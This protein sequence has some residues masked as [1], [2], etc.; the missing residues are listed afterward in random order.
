MEYITRY[1]KYCDETKP[2]TEWYIH[3]NGAPYYKCRACTRSDEKKRRNRI[4]DDSCGSMFVPLKPGVFADEQQKE[5]VHSILNTMGFSYNKE[6][7]I[8]WKKGFRKEDGTF[9]NLKDYRPKFRRKKIPQD[10][11]DEIYRLYK[12]EG[13][14]KASIARKL[15]V[16]DTYVCELLKNEKR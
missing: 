9:E 2:I 12:E 13:W 6:K 16:S 10:K 15:D 1:C 8:W 4:S 3:K 14:R 7:K 5:C 11:I